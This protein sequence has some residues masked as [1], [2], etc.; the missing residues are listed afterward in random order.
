M[1]TKKDRYFLRSDYFSLNALNVSSSKCDQ[2]FSNFALTVSLFYL[3][4]INFLEYH[5][6]IC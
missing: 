3:I 6:K 2:Y 4:K 5:N 1:Y